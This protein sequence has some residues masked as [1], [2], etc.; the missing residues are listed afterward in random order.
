M[1]FIAKVE[2]EI[3]ARDFPNSIFLLFET[4]DR[5]AKFNEGKNSYAKIISVTEK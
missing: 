2:F 1:K 4:L 5:A 3:E